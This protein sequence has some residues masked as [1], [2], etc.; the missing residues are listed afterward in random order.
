MPRVISVSRPPWY[1]LRNRVG[2]ACC[3]RELSLDLSVYQEQRIPPPIGAFARSIAGP[4]AG[5]GAAMRDPP[6][7]VRDPYAEEV[8]GLQGRYRRLGRWGVRERS[9]AGGEAEPSPGCRQPPRAGRRWRRLDG[10]L[11][12]KEWGGSTTGGRRQPTHLSF[13]F[14][15]VFNLIVFQRRKNMERGLVEEGEMAVAAHHSGAGDRG[16]IAAAWYRYVCDETAAAGIPIAG[17]WASGADSICEC[18]VQRFL[19]QDQQQ[20]GE[21]SGGRWCSHHVP[22]KV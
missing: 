20:S 18:S 7:F 4:A 14:I 13:W 16:P 5:V 8:L 10:H 12:R 11:R 9:T 1:V 3:S 6:I 22:S 17:L 2:P 15:V 19:E 21:K